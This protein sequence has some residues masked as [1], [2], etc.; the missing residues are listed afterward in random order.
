MDIVATGV[1]EAVDIG[2]ERIVFTLVDRQGINVR[3]HDH[4]IR[5]VVR[6]P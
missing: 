3:S 2:M 5:L 4:G 6:R 1:H